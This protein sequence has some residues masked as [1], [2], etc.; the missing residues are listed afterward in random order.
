MTMQTP[1]DPNWWR[2]VGCHMSPAWNLS[3]STTADEKKLKENIEIRQQREYAPDFMPIESLLFRAWLDVSS[4]RFQ[5]STQSLSTAIKYVKEAVSYLPTKEDDK[6]AHVGYGT[7]IYSFLLWLHEIEKEEEEFHIAELKLLDLHKS[8]ESETVGELHP[9]ARAYVHATH[10]FAL[11]R[12]GEEH[13]H[14]AVNLFKTALRRHPRNKNWQFCLAKILFRY[15]NM[16]KLATYGYRGESLSP[17]LEKKFKIVKAILERINQDNPN[18]HWANAYLGYV[19]FFLYG[20]I[21]PYC[22]TLVNE[23]LEHECKNIDIV[24]LSVRLYKQMRDFKRCFDLLEGLPENFRTAEVYFQQGILYFEE[25]KNDRSRQ[26]E[27]LHKSLAKIEA[28]LE[29]DT[30]K[31]PALLKRAEIYAKYPKL[32]ENFPVKAKGFYRDI[33]SKFHEKANKRDTFHVTRSMTYEKVAGIFTPLKRVN[34]CYDHFVAIIEA[35]DFAYHNHEGKLILS[36]EYKDYAP[37]VRDM[38]LKFSESGDEKYHIA[39]ISAKHYLAKCDQMMGEKEEAK[40]IYEGLIGDKRLDPLIECDVKFGLAEC[41]L[42]LGKYTEAKDIVRHLKINDR[43]TVVRKSKQLADIYVSEAKQLQKQMKDKFAKTIDIQNLEGC[44]EMMLANAN[45][46]QDFFSVQERIAMIVAK[47]KVCMK[48]ENMQVAANVDSMETVKINIKDKLDELLIQPM[49]FPPLKETILRDTFNSLS[50]LRSALL[51]FECSLLFNE[52]TSVCSTEEGSAKCSEGRCERQRGES[53]SWPTDC[54]SNAKEVLKKALSL[55]SQSI[56]CLQ[57]TLLSSEAQRKLKHNTVKFP[58]I[59]WR[60]E[61]EADAFLASEDL[62]TLLV[63]QF[64]DDFEAYIPPDMFDYLLQI[65]PRV[66]KKNVWLEVL[67]KIV[68]KNLEGDTLPKDSYKHDLGN[69]SIIKNFC[70]VHIARKSC[71]EAEKLVLTVLQRCQELL[72]QN[73]EKVGQFKQREE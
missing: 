6:F 2:S 5:N 13:L 24:L 38:L 20:K 21:T 32:D 7:V 1:Q 67:L 68:V 28:A 37:K 3:M 71:E 70:T 63:E 59:F 25:S 17:S 14:Q 64:P 4:L 41:Y 47:V 44:L 46:C 72:N 58:I 8:R 45:F 53:R 30:C 27:L 11:S 73:N 9:N 22:E 66:D 40:R 19:L 69:E 33:T 56:G 39:S 29:K 57:I 50:I 65:Q 31:F 15:F 43:P 26:T 34:N 35:D 16:Q 54:Q 51:E 62:Q 36:P 23:A 60:N 52:T 55:F 10:A 12:L 49:T 18:F 61:D 42:S 48:G